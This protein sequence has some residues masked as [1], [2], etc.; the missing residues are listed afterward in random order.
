MTENVGRSHIWTVHPIIA[1]VIAQAPGTAAAKDNPLG[2]S[3]AS[4][5]H[6]LVA[7]VLFIAFSS[8]YSVPATSAAGPE[9]AQEPEGLSLERAFQISYEK[10]YQILQA[11]ASLDAAQARLNQAVAAFLPKLNL[12][13]GYAYSNNPV[14]VF[15]N[16]MN[17]ADFQMEDF[18]LDTLN[19]PDFR[20]NYMARF[21][22]TQPVFNQ[23]LEYIGYRAAKIQH[24][25]TSLSMRQ[26]VQAALFQVEKAYC[27]ALLA[28]DQVEAL[29]MAFRTA[30]AHEALAE[31]RYNAGLVL[32][33][34]VLSARVQRG[35][36]ERELFRARNDLKLAVAALNQA[37]GL[38]QETR[39]SLKG[40]DSELEDE[41]RLSYWLDTARDSRPEL[42]MARKQQ[43][44]TEVQRR[45]AQLRFLPAVNLHGMYENNRH[46]LAHMG[47]E[48]WTFLATMSFNI[49][50]GLGDFQGLKAASAELEREQNRVRQMEAGIELEVRKAYFDFKTAKK[51]L[52][53]AKSAVEQAAESQKILKNRYENGLALM[54]ELLAADT[55]LRQEM[56]NMAKAAFDSRIAWASLKWKA[57]ILG[58]DLAPAPSRPAATEQGEM[59]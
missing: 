5:I 35:V 11:R 22:L 26:A 8:I 38:P 17:Q 49:F 44:L 59:K 14:M 20:G 25:I 6:A 4:V 31:K 27:Q 18:Q 42:L 57:G 46:N 19:H 51:Q 13:A 40:L 41:G 28:Q 58:G 21:I 16:K 55:A 39:W 53:V 3:L 52:K 47:G 23:G 50:N 1:R 7:A 33:S 24:E 36:V 54:V 48:S 30:K 2:S 37:M 29:E 9:A 56:L 43:E 12:E 10:N 45:Q 15:G 32:K 34:D